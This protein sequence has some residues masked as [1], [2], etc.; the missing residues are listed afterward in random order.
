MRKQFLP[1]LFVLIVALSARVLLLASN[2]VS[3]HSDEAVVG[4]MARHILQGERPVFFYGQAY[5]G[6]LDAWLVA[7]GFQLFGDTVPTIRIVQSVLYLLIVLTGYV[8]ARRFSGKTSIAAITGLMLAL[9][10]SLFALYTAA[11]LG[12]YSEALL[13]GNLVLLSGY[14]AAQSLAGAHTDAPLH[15]PSAADTFTPSKSSWLN[16]ISLGLAAGIGWWSNGLIVVYM[17]PV[18]AL[19]LYRLLRGTTAKIQQRLAWVGIAAVCFFV[20][21]APWWIYNF[22]HQWAAL[23]FYVPSL[24][25]QEDTHVQY[26]PDLRTEP[27]TFQETSGTGIG[28]RALGLVLFGLPALTG[29]RFSWASSFFLPI[30]GLPVTF[31]FLAALYT[32]A[33]DTQHKLLTSN[34]R[35]LT[36][37]MV[38][39]LLAIFILSQFGKDPTGR[40]LLPMVLPFSIAFAALVERV[41]LMEKATQNVR[42]ALQAALILIVVGY[43]VAGQINAASNTPGLTTQFDPISHIPNDDDDALISFL[44]AHDLTRGYT[45]Y[46]VAYRL[47]FLSD[48]QL[49]F[50]PALPYKTTL[51]HNLAEDRYP[52]Y[53]AIVAE[54]PDFAFITANSPEL[55]MLLVDTFNID[56]IDFE[57]EQI[58]A[59]TIYYGFDVLPPR[60]LSR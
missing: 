54:S 45:H 8:I 7:V 30:I 10:S 4:L 48:E 57:V 38:G 17:L 42:R 25:V 12:G 53:S 9:P 23:A 29:L 50:V 39:G 22:E 43:Q 60:P 6:S 14:N 56:G 41:N 37:G 26:L 16:W 31:L 3:F 15:I 27:A 28:D 55:D 52:A 18:G 2:T 24:S 19:L 34:G 11:S 40:Y 58:G 36:L 51:I 47:A 20:G 44:E 13:C 1:L 49:L 46:W 32:L 59:Y 35:I 5:M 21:S 33:R